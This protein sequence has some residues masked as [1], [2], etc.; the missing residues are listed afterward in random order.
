MFN[1]TIDKIGSMLLE[2]VHY[3]R[4]EI[5][6]TPSFQFH[7]DGS[8]CIFQK[9]PL[10]YG[11][12]APQTGREEVQRVYKSEN[13]RTTVFL[14]RK[15]AMQLTGKCQAVPSSPKVNISLHSP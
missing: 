6:F 7:S 10:I 9:K 5:V 4:V 15:C 2:T 8:G 11:N 14:I 12:D 13:K 3:G 1:C